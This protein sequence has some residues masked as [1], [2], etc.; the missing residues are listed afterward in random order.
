MFRKTLCSQIYKVTLFVF[1]FHVKKKSFKNAG[2]DTMQL[3][4]T[5]EQSSL[6]EQRTRTP[7]LLQK[8][9]YKPTMIVVH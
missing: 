6:H 1:L 8:V 3:K 9:N 7:T 5:P 4:P 2:V